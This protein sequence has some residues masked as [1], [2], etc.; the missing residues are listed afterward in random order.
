MLPQQRFVGEMHV[1][2][3][4]DQPDS[5]AS[6]N[7]E[8]GLPPSGQCDLA[9]RLAGMTA[10]RSVAAFGSAPAFSAGPAL[11]CFYGPTALRHRNS[12]ILQQ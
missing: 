12:A 6:L 11:P 9:A 5:T 4:V 10:E 3:V 2:G 1:S 7:T 8:M